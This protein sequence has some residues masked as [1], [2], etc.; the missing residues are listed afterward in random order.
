ME[1]S[2][3]PILL[4]IPILKNFR[5]NLASQLGYYAGTL[6]FFPIKLNTFQK[7]KV[8]LTGLFPGVIFTL[9][10]NLFNKKV[11]FQIINWPN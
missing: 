7:D 2:V 1:N 10:S 9:M 6:E 3:Q 5:E 4:A 11:F 8:L